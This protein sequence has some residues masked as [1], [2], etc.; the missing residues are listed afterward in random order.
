MV[1]LMMDAPCAGTSDNLWAKGIVFERD[2]PVAFAVWRDASYRARMY[3]RLESLPVYSPKTSDL[4]H[5]HFSEQVPQNNTL[6]RYYLPKS[7]LVFCAINE[8]T[9]EIGESSERNV[10][11]PDWG[12]V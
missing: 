2:P 11:Q 12:A 8:H 4:H 6:D 1:K 3:F 10:L 9:F 5:L 7:K